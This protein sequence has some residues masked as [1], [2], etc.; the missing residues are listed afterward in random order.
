MKITPF[1]WQEVSDNERNLCCPVC[2][3]TWLV[4][5]ES[6]PHDITPCNHLRFF[7]LSIV[8]EIQLFGK[9]DTDRFRKEYQ[10]S[11]MTFYETDDPEEADLNV[12]DLDVLERVDSREIDEVFDNTESGL[13]CGP[14]SST[15]L[16]GIKR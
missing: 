3:E 15:T 7:W 10:N 2:N 11:Y 5:D 9:W 13:T 14:V 16:W 4:D 12:L 8:G 6:G 1:E